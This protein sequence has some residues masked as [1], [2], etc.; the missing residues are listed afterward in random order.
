M[1]I[2]GFAGSTSKQSINA[3]LVKYTL[4]KV[5]AHQT[6]LLDL[7]DY[8]LP[9]F[10]EDLEREQGYPR[11]VEKFVK[12]IKE[13]DAIVVSM[14]EHNWSYTAAAKN[15]IDWCSRL[16][17][18]FFNNAPMLLMATSP[19]AYGG[20]NVLEAAEKR[21]PKFGADIVSTFKLP[22]F[23]DNFSGDEGITDQA[24]RD[25]H[26]EQLERLLAAFK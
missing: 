18:N 12:T 2:I 16:E 7:N 11:N 14:A 15:L 10:S 9:V 24:L 3:Q 25:S 21:F 6:Q 13:A 17:L 8:P 20:G 26:N 4:D 23:N 22:S 5:E 1:K 19:G